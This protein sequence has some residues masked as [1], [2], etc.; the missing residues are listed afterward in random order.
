MILKVA[1]K[2]EDSING[3]QELLKNYSSIELIKLSETS[4]YYRQTTYLYRIMLL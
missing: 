4:N 2:N 1:F 3:L